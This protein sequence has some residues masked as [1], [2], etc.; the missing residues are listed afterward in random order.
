MQFVWK[1][2]EGSGWKE[3]IRSDAR[4]YYGYITAIFHRNDLGNEPFA[5]E[6]VHR[7]PT[8]TLNKYFSG[9]SIMMAPWALTAHQIAH[10]DPDHVPFSVVVEHDAG[11]G[12]L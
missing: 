11:R 10:L 1:A 2:D 9:T 5:W 4:G 8:G 7:T 12:F 3:I 6:Y